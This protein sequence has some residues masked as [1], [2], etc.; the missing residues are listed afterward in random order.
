MKSL[1][2]QVNCL[3]KQKHFTVFEFNSLVYKVDTFSL[4]PDI[5]FQVV[6]TWPK[7]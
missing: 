2:T 7:Y 3:G 5:K 4:I 6:L 1:K